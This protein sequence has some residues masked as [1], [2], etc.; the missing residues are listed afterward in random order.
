[1]SAPK[2]RPSSEDGPNAGGTHGDAAA[3]W[4][5]PSTPRRHPKNTRVHGDE[6]VLLARTIVRTTWGAPVIVQRSTM[7]TIGGHGRLDAAE[8]ILRGIEVD[9]VMRGGADHYFDRDAPGPGLIPVRIVDVG[10]AEADAMALADNARAIQG[11]D[12]AALIVEMASQF[13]RDASVMADIG[14]DGEALD[15]L[16]Q[17]AGDAVLAQGDGATAATG[18]RPE[19]EE[20]EAPVD[21]AEE[22]REKWQTATGQLWEI[23]SE[24][25]GVHRLLCGDATN[26]DDRARALSGLSPA[27][28]FTDPPYDWDAAKQV[29]V[30]FAIAPAAVISGCGP[31]YARIASVEGVRFWYEVVSLR[32]MPRS[33]PRWPGPFVM[34]WQNA[35]IT[36]GGEHVFHRRNARGRFGNGDYFP[37][38]RGP[39]KCGENEHGHSKAVE[40]AHEI[41]WMMDAPVVCD[42]FSGS[43]T[44]L[45]A[46]EQCGRVCV[47]I[48]IDPRFV[49]VTL[50]RLAG[51]GLTPRL[52]A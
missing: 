16:V 7:R 45:M 36:T 27:V 37:S 51:R 14:F 28:V 49:A 15:A 30:C 35:F 12:D 17:A 9:G 43:G 2:R 13:G 22:L 52:I 31:Q 6:V 50:E 21:R 18:E 5:P 23:P 25:G 48:E 26:A 29:A 1:M 10:D 32:T 47:G 42:P 33:M 44:I 39:Y 4:L 3:V 46:A 24:H 8:M 41:L 34:H 19:V 38:V 40:W 20:D 11:T